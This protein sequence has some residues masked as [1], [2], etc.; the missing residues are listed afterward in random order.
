[1]K[2]L[3]HNNFVYNKQKIHF[4]FIARV[5]YAQQW[6]WKSVSF[7][8]NIFKTLKLYSYVKPLKMKI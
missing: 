4:Y 8:K 1:M 3:C 7:F 6:P 5:C 2:V